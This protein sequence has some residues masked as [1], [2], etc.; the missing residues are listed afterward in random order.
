MSS[1]VPACSEPDLCTFSCSAVQASP[2]YPAVV[3]R[4]HDNVFGLPDRSGKMAG[5]SPYRLARNSASY[6][7]NNNT[8]DFPSERIDIRSG[9][10]SDL[11][12]S[13]KAYSAGPAE[14]LPIS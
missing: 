11:R 8:E 9:G 12:F 10:I 3:K 5:L 14:V 4:S 1:L 6:Q 7:L 13:F 2:A